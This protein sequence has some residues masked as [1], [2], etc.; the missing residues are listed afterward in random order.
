MVACAFLPCTM[1]LSLF[2]S[3]L[4][5]AP[6]ACTGDKRAGSHTQ[7]F[8]KVS[9]VRPAPKFNPKPIVFTGIFL[10]LFWQSI[11]F[12]DMSVTSVIGQRPHTYAPEAANAMPAGSASANKVRPTPADKAVDSVVTISAEARRLYAQSQIAATQQSQLG[13]AGGPESLSVQSHGPGELPVDQF[14]QR[15]EKQI[16]DYY[17]IEKNEPIVLEKFVENADRAVE[18]AFAR[19][20][21]KLANAGISF[22]T[23]AAFS[24][25][26]GTLQVAGHSKAN[27]IEAVINSDPSLSRDVS[28]ALSMKAHATELQK[29]AKFT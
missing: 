22:N 7:A 21:A 15:A 10:A 6:D 18:A 4:A 29:A 11:G 28:A 8:N 25:T 26:G 3:S 1:L 12:A 17:G 13:V 14:V 9:L 16:R 24:A 2:N 20:R 23:P 27:E 19:V 5:R